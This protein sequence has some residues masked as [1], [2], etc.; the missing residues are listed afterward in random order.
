MLNSADPEKLN[1][2]EG[3]NEDAESHLERGIKWS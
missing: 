2:E 3:P 1:K